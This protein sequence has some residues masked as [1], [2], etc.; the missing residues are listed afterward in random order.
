MGANAATKLIKVVDNLRKI[1]AI[2]LI[3]ASQALHF[4]D[5]RSSSIIESFIGAFREQVPFIAE[6]RVLHYDI[7]KA[8]AFLRNT[9]LDT[10]ALSN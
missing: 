8:I 6:D 5:E 4:R 3:T 9:H 2:E 7:N 10:E 1:L